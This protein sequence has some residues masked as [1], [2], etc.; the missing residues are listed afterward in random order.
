MRDQTGSVIPNA[1]VTIRSEATKEEHTVATDADG[2]YT[3]PNLTPG[4]YTM[5]AGASGFK[6]FISSHN[7]LQSNSTIE[8]DGSLAL[9]QTTE[10]I[11]VSATAEVLQT[12]SGAVQAE[13][14]GTQIQNQELNGRSPIYTAQFLAGVRSGGTLGRL[15]RCWT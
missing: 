12:E 15:Q 1:K 7:N 2:H 4:E 14:T 10:S 11:E 3:V 8:L 6:Q 5:V 13:V 9:G